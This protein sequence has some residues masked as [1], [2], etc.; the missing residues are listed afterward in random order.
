MPR[1]T[2]I[3]P[4]VAPAVESGVAAAS[5]AGPRAAERFRLRVGPSEIDGLGVFAQEA[6]PA[7][8]KIGEM[9][10]EII[11]VAEARKRVRGQARV[12]VV[13][14]SARSAVDASQTP[15]ALR[16][17]NHSCAPNTSLQTRQ[18]RAEFFALRDIAAGEELTADYG[19]S[20]HEGRLVCRCGAPQC[21]GRL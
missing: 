16:H 19:A 17:I 9:R 12:H 1:L 15:G 14:I 21:K 13:E 7:R 11:P 8:S 3:E 18:G 20:H 2:V 4:S 5:D 6:I 10:G